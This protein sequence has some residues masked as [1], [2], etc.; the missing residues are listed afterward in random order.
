MNPEERA[1]WLEERKKHLGGSEV[2]AVLGLNPWKT[3]MDVWLEK[4]GRKEPDPPNAAMNRGIYL[5]DV[6]ARIYAEKTGR[7]LRAQ[8][9]RVHPEHNWLSCSID[10]QIFK[11]TG[12]GDYLTEKTGLLELK[13]PGIHVYSKL[14]A[15]GISD[16]YSLQLIH[17]MGVWGYA[18]SAFGAFSAERW[19]LIEFDLGFEP[20]IWGMIVEKTGPWWETH[21]L[22]DTPPEETEPEQI[23]LPKVEGDV[24]QRDDGEWKEAVDDLKEAYELVKTAEEVQTASKERVQEL[25]G[26]ETAVE[27]GCARVYWNTI[28]GRVSFDKK[29]LIAEHPEIHLEDY[30]KRG[31]SYKKF[32]PYFLTPEQGEE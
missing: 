23:D 4:T 17:N 27:G 28:K 21:V 9:L 31:A 13:C 2:A 7:Q 30:E 8:P 14:K 12:E 32:K 24:Q 20:E 29:K 16:A 11:G 26:E 3:A 15:K 18:W 1:A 22:G 6:A 5:E 25:M 10:R 19:E